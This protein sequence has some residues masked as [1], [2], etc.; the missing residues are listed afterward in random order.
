MTY[1]RG[2]PARHIQHRDD[3][4]EA[5]AVRH[6]HAAIAMHRNW[7]TP[8]MSQV[9]LD[10][11]AAEPAARVLD[12]GC[13]NGELLRQILVAFP[14]SAVIGIDGLPDHVRLTRERLAPWPA[15]ASALDLALEDAREWPA[16]GAV[17]CITLLNVLHFIDDVDLE[18]V[19]GELVR[20]LEPGGRLLTSQFVAVPADWERGFSALTS[21]ATKRNQPTGAEGE[22]LA[23]LKARYRSLQEAGRI[24]PRSNGQ[25]THGQERLR[26][27]MTAAGLG[28]VVDVARVGAFV[29]LA[30]RKPSVA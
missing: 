3:D 25:V 12:V 29:M 4:P 14:A 19:L 11:L 24:S 28:S 21:E 2:M 15:R 26:Q 18:P 8:L 16:L 22:R 27:A 1:R 5:A 7:N 9:I 13:G 6:A 23:D 10:L 20:R 30:G 17:D